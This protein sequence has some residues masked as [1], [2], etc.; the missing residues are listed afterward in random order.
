MYESVVSL[1]SYATEYL[2]RK[3][4]LGSNLLITPPKSKL[5]LFGL[6]RPNFFWGAA[7]F[8]L[9]MTKIGWA[10]HKFF[11]STFKL[12]IPI[13]APK[14]GFLGHNSANKNIN[15]CGSKKHIFGSNHMFWYIICLGPTFGLDCRWVAEKKEKERHTQKRYIAP[16]RGEVPMQPADLQQFLLWRSGV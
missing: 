6:L 5:Q 9:W 8:E 13:L 14:W 11:D 4:P 16:I 7:S 3:L 2:A 15:C 1:K 10:V 12:Q